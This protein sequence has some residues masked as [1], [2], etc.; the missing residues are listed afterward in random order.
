MTT[1]SNEQAGALANLFILELGDEG[2]QF[3]GRFFADMGATVIKIE[4]PGGAGSRHRGPF[5]DGKP[6]PN[7]SIYFWTYNTSKDSI[8]L[9]LEREEDRDTLRSL[10]ER[11]DVVLEDYAPGYLDS[12]GLG[13]RQL[14]PDGRLVMTSVTPFGQTGPL[15]DWKGSDMVYWAMGG[16]MWNLG[17]DDPATPP[18]VA[19][20][21]ITYQFAGMWAAIGT[22]A[23]LAARDA[24]GEGQH[25]DVSIQEACAF[26][27]HCYNTAAFEYQGTVTRRHDY[28]AHVITKD[29]KRVVPQILN[30]SADRW[31]AF[32]DWL[33][34]QG[35]GEELHD[36]DAETLQK[37]TELV[38]QVIQGLAD[39]RDAREMVKIG[40]SFGFTW[41]AVNAPEELLEDE[42][43]R[44]RNFFQDVHHPEFAT[45][46]VYGGPAAEWSE[47]QWRIRRRP[48][49]LGEDNAKWV[50]SARRP[51]A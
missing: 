23:A 3:C 35:E 12:L 50:P 51:Q 42:Q 32:R 41:A 24:I 30:V 4:P 33:K 47:A 5:K 9:D 27:V 37:S 45:S 15:K 11:A 14:S 17:Y 18:L 34:E 29:G 39:K 26:G 44:A 1:S 7:A 40:Q 22:M 10:A 2:T 43:L 21:E 19:Q 48:P 31:I 20:G 25:V 16:M 28:I 49:L 8:T 38:K 6:D 36:L 13:Y 46:F